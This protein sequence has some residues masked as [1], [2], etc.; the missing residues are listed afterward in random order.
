M[1]DDEQELLNGQEVY[2]IL[3]ENLEYVGWNPITPQERVMIINDVKPFPTNAVGAYELFLL[4]VH[5]RLKIHANLTPPEWQKLEDLRP[6][7][8]PVASDVAPRMDRSYVIGFG[9]RLRLPSMRTR[10]NPYHEHSADED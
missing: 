10:R 4:L 2:D 3:A 5:H 7:D 8:A 6:T 1:A 9:N